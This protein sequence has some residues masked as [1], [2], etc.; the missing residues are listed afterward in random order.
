VGIEDGKIISAEEIKKRAAE[1]SK[2][3]EDASKE[4]GAKGEKKGGSEA[5]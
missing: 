3:L 2:K 1:A 4:G 5:E